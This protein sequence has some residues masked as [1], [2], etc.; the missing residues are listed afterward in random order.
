MTLESIVII[1]RLA[2]AVKI[3]ASRGLVDLKDFP[4]LTFV[5]E[6]LEKDRIQE[7]PWKA[8]TFSDI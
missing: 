8:F 7:F 1:K 3:K 4:M 5:D 2:R 6:V